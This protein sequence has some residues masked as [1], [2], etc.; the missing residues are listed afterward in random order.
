MSTQEFSFPFIILKAMRG[1]FV[2]L[3][4]RGQDFITAQGI[5]L[6]MTDKV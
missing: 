3:P 5:F 1:E 4:T 2:P 6:E